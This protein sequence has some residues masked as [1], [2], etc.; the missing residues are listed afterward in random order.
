MLFSFFSRLIVLES[1]CAQGATTC[2]LSSLARFLKILSFLEQNSSFW[3]FCNKRFFEG[4]QLREQGERQGGCL[5][6]LDR[7]DLHQ[8]GA[9]GPFQ[10][11]GVDLFCRYL[12]TLYDQAM[13]TDPLTCLTRIFMIICGHAAAIS[14]RGNNKCHIHKTL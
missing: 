9:L 3:P 8:R 2:G 11:L 5:T 12:E 13:I 14:R 4:D 7:Q 6:P 1:S 10:C